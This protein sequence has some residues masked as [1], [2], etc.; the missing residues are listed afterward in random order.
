MSYLARQVNASNRSMR[1]SV[2]RNAPL[3]SQHEGPHRS[4]VCFSS[5]GQGVD[6]NTQV[7]GLVKSSGRGD[8]DVEMERCV[9][10]PVSSSPSL[11]TNTLPPYGFY[12]ELALWDPTLIF[13]FLDFLKTYAGH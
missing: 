4:G 11:P 10:T 9:G 7:S 5:A 3:I 8:K 1:E 13:K 2:H 12:S 6:I